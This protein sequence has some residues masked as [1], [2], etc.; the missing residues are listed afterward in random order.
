MERVFKGLMGYSAEKEGKPATHIILT[1]SEYEALLKQISDKEMEVINIKSDSENKINKLKSDNLEYLK[2][3]S[4]KF[5]SELDKANSF[6]KSLQK[7]LD[8]ANSL[9]SNLLRISRERANSKRG[10]K[11]KKIHNGYLVLDCQQ[12]LYKF[13]GVRKQNGRIIK[14]TYNKPCWK[15]KIQSHYDSSIPFEIIKEKIHNDY[16]NIFGASLGI[17]MTYFNGELEE[18]SKNEIDSLWDDDGN[19]IFKISYKSNFKTGLWEVE[20][21]TRA[22]ITVPE[23]M[24]KII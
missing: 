22:S 23:D 10:L 12:S 6:S 13:N 15:V 11:P 5:K 21:L 14:F 18:K 20:Y 1:T 4:D 7:D 16:I 24:R 2:S 19:F 3:L 17:T 9:N 8:T